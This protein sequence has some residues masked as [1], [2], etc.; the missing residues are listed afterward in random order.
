ML[1]YKLKENEA[2]LVITETIRGWQKSDVRNFYVDLTTWE[3]FEINPVNE[4]RFAITSVKEEDKPKYLK[5]VQKAK[6][7]AIKD[8]EWAIQWIKSARLKLSET[9]CKG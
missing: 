5:C 2:V 9:K 3:R 6:E 8:K 4:T 7:Q 1:A